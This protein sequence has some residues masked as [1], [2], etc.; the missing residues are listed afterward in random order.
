[1]NLSVKKH[2]L[3]D[4]SKVFDVI[5][6]INDENNNYLTIANATNEKTAWACIDEIKLAISKAEGIALHPTN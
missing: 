1:M 5:F 3:T 6:Y 4:G 2:K